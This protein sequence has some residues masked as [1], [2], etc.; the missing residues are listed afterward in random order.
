M[1]VRDAQALANI[2]Q[3]IR[4]NP[5]NDAAV[6][7]GG[8][9][10]H[11]GNRALLERPKLGFLASRGGGTLHGKLP[12]KPDEVV[13][14]GFLSPMERAVFRATLTSHRPVIWVKPWAPEEGTDAPEIQAA[15]AEGRLL[16]LSPFADHEAPSAQRAAW[17]NEYVMHRCDRLVLGHLKSGGMLECLLSDAP[18]ELDIRLL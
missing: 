16:I 15:L 1:I 3:Y 8:E 6:A 5:Q 12:M 2:R 7:Q 10:R 9:P 18:P 14:S 11:L 17:C 13:L 4:F